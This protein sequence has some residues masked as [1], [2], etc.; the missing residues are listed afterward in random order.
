MIDIVISCSHCGEPLE[1]K[2]T[3]SV[4]KGCFRLGVL[5]CGRCSSNPADIIK[6][7]FE[8]MGQRIERL[9]DHLDKERLTTTPS[10][11]PGNNQS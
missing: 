3:Y 6:L 9:K 1:V 10:N 8:Q 4:A 2:P 7:C 5:P 11:P